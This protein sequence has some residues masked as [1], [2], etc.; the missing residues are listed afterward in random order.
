MLINRVIFSNDPRY[1]GPQKH[2]LHEVILFYNRLGLRSLT[3]AAL[4]YAYRPTGYTPIGFGYYTTALLKE[5]RVLKV[6]E[7][8]TRSSKLDRSKAVDSIQDRLELAR[9]YLK[10]YLADTTVDIIPHPISGKDCVALTQAHVEGELLTKRPYSKYL[11][12]TQRENFAKLLDDAKTLLDETGYLLDV[13][14]HN[15][16]A[17]E[18]KVV[19]VDTILMGKV[20]VKMRPITLKILNGEF[21]YINK[22]ALQT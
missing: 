6:Y 18:D 14:G 2:R 3:L 16:I 10:P 13:N 22:D 20:D 8:S 21:A 11:T 4:R 5:N 15:M 7:F 12:P 1:Y 17:S 19:V 9:K